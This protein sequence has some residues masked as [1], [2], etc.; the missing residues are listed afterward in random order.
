MPG[1]SEPRK[2]VELAQEAI[3]ALNIKLSNKKDYPL[4]MANVFQVWFLMGFWTV[5]NYAI[6]TAM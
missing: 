1:L 3:I 5:F 4:N 2:S 6:L